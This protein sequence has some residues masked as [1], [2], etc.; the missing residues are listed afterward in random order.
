[1][2]ELR[3]AVALCID[4]MLAAYLVVEVVAACEN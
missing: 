1:M 4:L 2:K 3:P